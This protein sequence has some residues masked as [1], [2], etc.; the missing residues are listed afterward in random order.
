M[1]VAALPNYSSLS[2]ESVFMHQ[3]ALHER[4]GEKG[5]EALL[6]DIP[7]ALDARDL[8]FLTDRFSDALEKRALSVVPSDLVDSPSPTAVVTHLQS[9]DLKVLSQLL[10]QRLVESQRLNA[11]TGLLVVADAELDG[12]PGVLIAKVEHQEAMQAEAT[13]LEGGVRSIS[14]KRIP[15]LVFGEQ[16]RIYKIAILQETDRNSIGVEGFLADIQNG[17]GFA[18]YFLG[19]FLGLKLADEPEV[20]TE[21]FLDKM[22]EA[23]HQSNLGA[24]EKMEA[25]AALAVD[26]KSNSPFVDA[27]AFIRNHIPFSHQQNIRSAAS[28]RGVPMMSFT[29]DHKRISNRLDNLRINLGD[30]ISLLAPPHQIGGQGQVQVVRDMSSTGNELYDVTIKGV[31]LDSVTNSRPR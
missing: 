16:S 28:V 10:A 7:V 22:T 26:I 11:K 6:T 1:G 8:G 14:I 30:E 9:A 13:T 3:I 12:M 5:F 20:L 23:I 21:R 2:L 4:N 19:E 15:D 29:K 27:E 31:P 17:G 25:Q 24:G 18:N